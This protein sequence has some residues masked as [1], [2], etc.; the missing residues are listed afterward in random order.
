M[1]P[2]GAEFFHSTCKVSSRYEGKIALPATY[3]GTETIEA[4]ARYFG[5]LK[6]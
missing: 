5:D 1:G 3:S 6:E 2:H 4:N